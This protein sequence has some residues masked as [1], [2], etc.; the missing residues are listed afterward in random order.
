M[1][2]QPLLDQ[3][4]QQRNGTIVNIDG[5]DAG[6]CTAVVHC[7]N[8]LLNMPLLL[9]NAIQYPQTY[10]HNLYNLIIN[11]PT[12]APQPG[13]IIIYDANNPVLGTGPFGHTG[14]C[15]AANV[16]NFDS[17]E[18]NDEP[19]VAAHI[20]SRASYEG[21]YGWLHPVQLTE[22]PSPSGPVMATVVNASAGLWMHSGPGTSYTHV[23]GTDANGNP[24]ELLPDGIS[25]QVKAIVNGD[26]NMG[27]T[28]N[29][30]NQWV[31][32]V[33]DRFVTCAFLS[34]S[35][36]GGTKPFL[37]KVGDLLRKGN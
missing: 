17:F 26:P 24:I 3:M 28:V 30:N 21:V 22:A 34:I 33:H 2:A 11:S 31:Q 15:V 35:Q 36:Q 4:I 8:L 23:N 10:Q 19:N 1:N 5:A 14:V 37:G 18:Q 32:S 27:G 20:Q 25:F 6:Q 12:N 9:G 13:D 16:E 7:W 29:G